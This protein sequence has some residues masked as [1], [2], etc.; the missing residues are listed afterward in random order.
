MQVAATIYDISMTVCSCYFVFEV[1]EK[2]LSNAVYVINKKE[3][4]KLAEN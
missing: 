1:K 2:K 4:N 3:W